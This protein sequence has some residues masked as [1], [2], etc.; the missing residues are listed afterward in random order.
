ML[1]RQGTVTL[2]QDIHYIRRICIVCQKKSQDGKIRKDFC[3]AI[4][5][6]IYNLSLPLS[7]LKNTSKLFKLLI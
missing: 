6:Y 7:L 1:F 3:I 4:V 2:F 5:F